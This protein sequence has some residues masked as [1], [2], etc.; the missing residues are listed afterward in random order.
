M[1]K[2]SKWT[3][4]RFA[5]AR[6]NNIPVITRTVQQRELVADLQFSSPDYLFTV[7][8]TWVSDFKNTYRIW[9]CK[10]T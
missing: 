10:V 9:Q 5:E 3:F 1:E 2:I 6:R 8:R 4:D 7:S